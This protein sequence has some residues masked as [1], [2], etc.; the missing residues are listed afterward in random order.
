MTRL[1]GLIA[2]YTAAAIRHGEGMRSG[3]NR[4]TNRATDTIMGLMAD[5]EK[6]G[7]P[8]SKAFWDLMD[9]EDASVRCCVASECLFIPSQENKAVAVLDE[10]SRGTGMVAF[11]AE[12]VLSEWR[13]DELHNSW[14]SGRVTNCRCPACRRARGEA[15]P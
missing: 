10:I 8:H 14:P 15:L 1:Q 6:E 4:K 3:N 7:A 2:K 13:K 9:H 5:L 11:D 12:M